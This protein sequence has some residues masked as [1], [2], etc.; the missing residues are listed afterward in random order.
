[1]CHRL[2]GDNNENGKAYNNV[3]Y[4]CYLCYPTQRTR[5]APSFLGLK[6]VTHNFFLVL[7]RVTFLCY[8]FIFSF[9]SSDKLIPLLQVWQKSFGFEQINALILSV[10]FHLSCLFSSIVA[11]K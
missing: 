6:K 2:D 10:D 4:P 8:L 5:I 9:R 3:C 11:D 7:P 1:M